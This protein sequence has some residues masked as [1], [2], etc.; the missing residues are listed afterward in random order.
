[1][2]IRMFLVILVMSLV[3]PWVSAQDGD[4]DEEDRERNRDRSR[5]NDLSYIRKCE[6]ILDRE[7]QGGTWFSC[8]RESDVDNIECC[9]ISPDFG[10]T[11]AP[12]AG[13]SCTPICILSNAGREKTLC[14][15]TSW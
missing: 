5:D 11:I 10:K 14:T 13:R 9:P 6:R 8:G 4:E 12:Y 7:P 1:M 3:S 15:L 2:K